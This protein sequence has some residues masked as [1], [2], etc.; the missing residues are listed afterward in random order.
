[1]PVSAIVE[2]V[3]FLIEHFALVATPRHG[4]RHEFVDLRGT[5]V[6]R[7]VANVLAVV[8]LKAGDGIHVLAGDVEGDDGALLFLQLRFV[9]FA[10]TVGPR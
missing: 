6:A 8:D 4:A 10:A 3:R 7:E 2:G 9:F 1:M 5:H